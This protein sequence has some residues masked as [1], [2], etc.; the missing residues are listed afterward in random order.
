MGPRVGGPDR[1]SDRGG[2]SGLFVWVAQD[3]KQ[4]AGLAQRLPCAV[5]NLLQVG[6]AGFPDARAPAACSTTTLR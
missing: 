6:P 2:E 3:A 4:A 1:G 5:L